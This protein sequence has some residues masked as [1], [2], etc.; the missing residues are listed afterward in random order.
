MKKTKREGE[1]GREGRIEGRKENKEEGEN[2]MGQEKVVRSEALWEG[3]VWRGRE[4]LDFGE[5]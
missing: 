5:A 3:E 4:R 2:S 1:G